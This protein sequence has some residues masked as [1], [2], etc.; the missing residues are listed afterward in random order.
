MLRAI[1]AL[2]ARLP[3]DVAKARQDYLDAVG[4]VLSAHTRLSAAGAAAVDERLAWGEVLLAE[5]PSTI[6]AGRTAPFNALGKLL[7]FFFSIEDGECQVER[8]LAVVKDASLQHLGA[9]NSTIGQQAIFKQ[10]PAGPQQRSDLITATNHSLG[11]GPVVAPGL[12]G[13]ARLG[14][15][16]P[17]ELR[18]SGDTGPQRRALVDTASWRRCTENLC[19]DPQRSP[20]CGRRSGGCV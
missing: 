19:P 10:D 2:A 9:L 3:C 12:R 8:D 17:Q 13:T 1:E 7:R 16:W 4:Y 15:W 20:D 6:C 14:V 11:L 5:D 18:R